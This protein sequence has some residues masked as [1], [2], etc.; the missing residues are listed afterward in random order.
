MIINGERWRIKIVP[1][2]DPVLMYKSTT[3]AFGCCDDITKIIYLN[4]TLAPPQMKHV[5]CHE[6]VHAVMYSYNVDLNKEIEEKVADI[7]M[8][9]GDKIIKLT[10]RSFNNLK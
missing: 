10:N 7:I 9:Y 6:I 3:P 1:P 2:S 8:E 4:Q 5:L